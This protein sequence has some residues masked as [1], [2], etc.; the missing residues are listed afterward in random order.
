VESDVQAAIRLAGNWNVKS[1]QIASIGDVNQDGTVDVA[2]AVTVSGVDM[3]A[4]QCGD[5]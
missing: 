1:Q 3:A 5:S 2:G 4:L